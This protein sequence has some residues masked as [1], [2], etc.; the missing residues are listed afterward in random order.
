M[1]PGN[2]AGQFDIPS[3]DD[4]D[5]YIRVQPYDKGL[6]KIDSMVNLKDKVNAELMFLQNKI[7]KRQNDINT[8]LVHNYI[9][10]QGRNQ[11]LQYKKDV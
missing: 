8:S 5:N 4:E 10:S 9:S 1:K 2:Y 7:G 3:N 11:I 6:R